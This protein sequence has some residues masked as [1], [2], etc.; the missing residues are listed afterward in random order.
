MDEL[1][2]LLRIT[3]VLLDNIIT[4]VIDWDKEDDFDTN[5][6]QQKGAHLRKLVTTIRSCGVGFDVWEPKNPADKKSSGTCE[7]TSLLGIDKK[8]LLKFLPEKLP[9]VLRPNTCSD[10]CRLW[11]D[12]RYLYNEIHDWSP[13][14]SPECYF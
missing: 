2:L 1:H 9:T 14:K 12:F 13:Q 4:E 5:S 10:L 3:D 6:N 11:A 7:F 8:K